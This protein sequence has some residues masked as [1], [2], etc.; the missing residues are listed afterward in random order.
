MTEAPRLPDFKPFMLRGLT[1]AEVLQQMRVTG[2]AG[3][4]NHWCAPVLVYEGSRLELDDDGERQPWTAFA[5]DRKARDW[6]M[7]K[8]DA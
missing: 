5:D 6:E 3:R 8:R 2:C 7:V 1:Y 4:R